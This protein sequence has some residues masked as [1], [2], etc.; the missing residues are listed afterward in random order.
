M[1][2]KRCGFSP[3][4]GKLPWRRAWQ[5]APVFLPRESHGQRSLVA[6]I[7]TAAELTWRKQLGTH[8]HL[9]WDLCRQGAERHAA[10][11]LMVAHNLLGTLL[12]FSSPHVESYWTHHHH[13]PSE[14][15]VLAHGLGSA[16]QTSTCKRTWRHQWHHWR[17]T[18]QQAWWQRCF[19][20]WCQCWQSF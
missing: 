19:V 15:R 6:I 16:H 17:W 13:T 14:A 7:H 3:W 9:L 11:P 20:S 10:L 2:C 1:R 8:M 12:I 5:P 4:V 18:S